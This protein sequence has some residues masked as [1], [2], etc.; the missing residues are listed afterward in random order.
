VAAAVVIARAVR[1]QGQAV[2]ELNPHLL[3]T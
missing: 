3:D 2:L 1:Q